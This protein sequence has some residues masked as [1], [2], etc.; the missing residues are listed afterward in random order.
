MERRGMSENDAY[1][2]LRKRA[3]D[4]GVKVAEI[5]RQLLSVADLLG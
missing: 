1:A 4:Q 5:A 3:M 2:T